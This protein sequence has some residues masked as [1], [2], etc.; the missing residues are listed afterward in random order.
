MVKLRWIFS[1]LGTL[2]RRWK[3]PGWAGVNRRAGTVS[4]LH[5][6]CIAALDTSPRFS[7]LLLDR[8][9]RYD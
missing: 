6:M 4:F 7:I 2:L 1:D 9:C 8:N 5:Q 3:L